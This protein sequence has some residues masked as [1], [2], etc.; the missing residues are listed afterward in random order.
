[1]KNNEFSVFSCS[2][3]YF[4]KKKYFSHDID[5]KITGV[6]ST[7]SGTSSSH[8]E[9]NLIHSFMAYPEALFKLT[10][11]LHILVL[12]SLETHRKSWLKFA[13]SRRLKDI[14]GDIFFW[15]CFPVFAESNLILNR[16]VKL[17][18]KLNQN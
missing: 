13:L 17:N 10:A 1:L 16:F 6:T 11:G 5:F 9:D 4:E 12:K 2:F 7:V 8:L 18:Q 15:S 14:L 3:V